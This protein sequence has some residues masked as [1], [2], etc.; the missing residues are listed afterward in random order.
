MSRLDDVAMMRVSEILDR[1]TIVIAGEGVESLT[2]GTELQVLAVGRPLKGIG[3]P[4]LVPKANVEVTSVAGV[5]AI[6]RSPV[7]TEQKSTLVTDLFSR[8]VTKRDALNVDESNLLGNPASAPIAKGDPVVRPNQLAELVKALS[9][10]RS[11]DDR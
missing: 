9:D 1:T 4:L 11:G 2:I 5:Y 10:S 6:A 8:S 7:Y 3:V